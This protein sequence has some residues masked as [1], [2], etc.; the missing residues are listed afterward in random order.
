MC[1]RCRGDATRG[2]RMR[3]IVYHIHHEIYYSQSQ[4]F[5]FFGNW[6]LAH[7]EAL[8]PAPK[9]N[10]VTEE[11]GPREYIFPEGARR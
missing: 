5:S 9:I 3:G 7:K 2:E 1:W 4:S 8:S 10:W 6:K 11:A